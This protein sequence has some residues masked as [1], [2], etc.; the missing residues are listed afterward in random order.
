MELERYAGGAA[1]HAALADVHRL[2]IVDQL[3]LTDLSPKE[4]GAMLGVDSNLLAH[5]LGI[6]EAAGLIERIASQGDRRR[7][8]IRLTTAARP[9]AQPTASMATR[10]VVFVCT[11]NA[12]RSQLAQ[13]I[14]N[15]SQQVQAISA[16]TRPTTRLHPGTIRAAARR[17]IDLKD[18]RPRPLL[19]LG[20]GDLVITVCDRAH[21]TLV[22]RLGR[23]GLHWSLPDP[24]TD[25][26][27]RAYD[28]SAEA[29]AERI[30]AAA[31]HIAA[32]S[33]SRGS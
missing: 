22:N 27:P 29:I 3:F 18:A 13:G 32:G 5:H 15:Q 9:L 30:T 12:G 28:N 10:R 23:Y 26:N 6:L 14:W 11:E 8:Y 7:R 2:A 24:A 31:E 17:G 25:R 21:E 16:G 20:S 1:V 4:L 33:S 19:K